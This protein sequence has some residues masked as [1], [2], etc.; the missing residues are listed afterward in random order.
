M[1]SSF[2]PAANSADVERF[3]V[4]N[5]TLALLQDTGWYTAVFENA[6]RLMICM[7]LVYGGGNAS[8][9][10]EQAAALAPHTLLQCSPHT[11]ALLDALRC[12]L[13]HKRTLL[14]DGAGL[15]YLGSQCGLFVCVDNMQYLRS[16]HTRA[17]LL[18]QHKQPSNWLRA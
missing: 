1:V 18:L 8:G 3:V 12:M 11:V 13:I 15:Q 5:M 7:H 14:T 4:S 9:N 17:A 2:L 6:V 10:F 16:D